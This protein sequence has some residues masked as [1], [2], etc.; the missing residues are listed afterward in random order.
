M[1]VL[2]LRLQAPMMSFGGPLVDQ[3]GVIQDY[4]ALSMLTGLLGNALG[5]HHRDAERLNS[6]QDRIRYAA[7]CDRPGRC[8]SDYQTVD[9]GQDFLRDSGWTSRG[10]PEP[11]Y[12]DAKNKV[13]THIRHRQYLADAA[14]TLALALKPADADPSLD[15]LESALAQPARPLFL[16]SKCCLPAAPVILGR[17]IAGSLRS[18]LS[19]EPRWSGTEVPGPLRA[20]WPGEEDEASQRSSSVPVTDERDWRNQIVV[21][22]RLVRK[23]LVDP[24]EARDEQ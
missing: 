21:G 17:R 23:G 4:P 9:L 13:G 7:R 20:W 11:R 19:T 5:Y 15:S 14:Y 22:R 12:G 1:E 16:G 24:P 10:R 2:L 3:R 18:V 8:I 6:L